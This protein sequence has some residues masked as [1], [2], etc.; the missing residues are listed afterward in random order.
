[1]KIKYSQILTA[2]L[3][4]VLTI[5]AVRA[6]DPETVTFPSKDDLMI[7]ADLYAPHKEKSTPFIVLF[8]QAGWSRGEY[9]EIAPKLNDLGFNCMAIDQRSGKAVNDVDNETALRAMTA[10]KEMNYAATIPDLEAALA[11]AR[12]H[13][14]KGKVVAWGSSYSAS[15]VLKIAGDRP[16]LIDA[17]LAFSPGEYFGKLGKSETWIEE[18]AVKIQVPVFIT[19]ARK[20]AEQWAA[21]FEAI[22]S[23]KKVSYIPDTEGNHGSRALWEQFDDREGYWTVVRSFLE[24]NATN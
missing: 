23:E 24:K 20:E 15:L 22:P 1:M 6:A 10:G 9:R 7:T 2:L 11:Y 5:P 8:H 19:S 16:E 18:S 14:T 17:A 4:V 12:E 3:L 13:H 21:I